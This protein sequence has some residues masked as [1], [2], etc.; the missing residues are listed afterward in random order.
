[1]RKIIF[2]LAIALILPLAE[3]KSGHLPLLAV[4]ELSD[5]TY[6]GST[7]DIY[8]EVKPGS[9]RVFIDTFPITRLDTQMTT[10]FAKEMACK[11]IDKECRDYDFF[12]TISADS[13]IVAG[14][15]AGA[16]TA[17]LTVSVLKGVPLND[18]IYI[19]GT[20]NS[21]Y[22]IGP[23]GGLKEKIAAASESGARKVLIP[24]GTAEYT[25]GNLTV[26]LV[27]FGEERNV[28]V[29]E[30][31]DLASALAEYTEKSFRKDYGEIRNSERYEEIMRNLAVSLCNRSVVLEGS[32]DWGRANRSEFEYTRNLTEKSFSEFEGRRYYSSASMCFGA[33]VN[34]LHELIMQ[35]D[36]TPFNYALRIGNLKKDARDF[37]EV[38][39]KRNIS[40]I[41]DLEANIVVRERLND[42][43]Y[44]ADLAKEANATSEKARLLS[45][46]IER[47]NSANLW[48]S[49]YGAGGE[50]I[51]LDSEAQRESCQMK[52]SEAEERYQYAKLYFPIQLVEIRAEIN[53]ARDY[54]EKEEYP[55]CLFSATK[56][57]A[58]SNTILSS[59]NVDVEKVGILLDQ[60]LSAAK[61]AIGE[62]IEKGIF[63]VL[64]YSYYEYANTLRKDDEFSAL[65][66]SEYALELSNLD[67]YF[68]KER[69]LG[70]MR[71]D[72]RYLLLFLGGTILGF[73]V[74]I[75]AGRRS[76]GRAFKKFKRNSSGKKQ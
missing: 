48:D 47:V 55:F 19:T 49:F 57:K 38:V 45:Y 15:S 28:S 18:G 35:A 52:I 54:L 42:A 26:D 74:G 22:L 31:S 13:S 44:Y 50:R 29:V 10:R 46:A 58:R 27:R 41:M 62:E 75:L 63:P 73:S 34:Y 16:A 69:R 60:K 39:R 24:L 66:Y 7:A 6:R 23:V 37:E 30:V 33:N 65:I 71:I 8:L 51:A 72:H 20:I 14:P 25:D 11:F 43:I 67:I 53:R 9:G 32:I 3:G 36:L 68:K 40:T 4:S 1:M 5:G 61:N 59:I 2:F 56:A 70:W 21:G 64:G 12:Y 76:G 17:I